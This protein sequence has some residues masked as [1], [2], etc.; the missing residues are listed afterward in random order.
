[1]KTAE[2]LNESQRSALSSAAPGMPDPAIRRLVDELMVSMPGLSDLE[3]RK[4][5]SRVAREFCDR[6]NCWSAD[7]EFHPV[8]DEPG[9]DTRYSADAPNGAVALRVRECRY[10]TWSWA[11]LPPFARAFGIPGPHPYFVFGE[12]PAPLGAFRLRAC[13]LGGGV[14]PFFVRLVLAPQIGGE[15]LPD[16]LVARWGDAFV[17][18]ARATLCAMKDRRWS[19][20][21][22]A[23]IA[24]QRY[25]TAVSE[26]R[27]EFECAGVPSHLQTRSKIPFLI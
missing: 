20:P 17:N 9:N 2:E 22:S 25:A 1:M 6:T 7:R 12:L 18:G 4:E 16:E 10:G 11:G 27:S 8:H 24:S 3:A 23:A 26:A 14:P 5:L 21:Q 19:D 13:A 15:D